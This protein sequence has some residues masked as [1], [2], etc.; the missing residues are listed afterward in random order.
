MSSWLKVTGRVPKT[1]DSRI[2]AA[3]PPALAQ[4][5]SR[6]VWSL[7]PAAD[8]SPA[9]ASGDGVAAMGLAAQVDTQ[10][11]GPAVALFVVLAAGLV[12]AVGPDPA[13]VVQAATRANPTATATA[14]GRRIR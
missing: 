14:A 8:R 3:R 10:W 7:S 5:T 11:R 2:R 9:E 6:M 1:F 13:V 4:T 12:V